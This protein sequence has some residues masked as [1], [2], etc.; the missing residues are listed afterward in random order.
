[1]TAEPKT[2]PPTPTPTP[3]LSSE[4]EPTTDSEA[5]FLAWM[6][7]LDLEADL[8]QDLGEEPPTKRSP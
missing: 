1:M 5:E 8:D 7:Q 4:P 2:P 3:T 6:D